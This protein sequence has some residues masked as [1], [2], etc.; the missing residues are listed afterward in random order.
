MNECCNT[1][2]IKNVSIEEVN[3][4]RFINIHLKNDYIYKF[5]VTANSDMAIVS[6]VFENMARKL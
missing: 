1:I 6:S 3:D 5:N 4:D 2:Q